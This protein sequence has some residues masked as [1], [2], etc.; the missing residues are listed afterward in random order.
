DLLLVYQGDQ[1]GAVSYE[2]L[3]V[4]CSPTRFIEDGNLPR[5]A[6]IVD[7][8]W[9]YVNKSGGPDRRFS[10]NRQLPVVQYAHLEIKSTTGLNIHLQASNIP[11]AQQFAALLRGSHARAPQEQSSRQSK[12]SRPGPSIPTPAKK[13]AYDVLGISRSATFD[14]VTAAYHKLARM[15]HPD[16]VADLAPEFKELAERRMKE[17]NAAYESLKKEFRAN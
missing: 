1:Y 13:S 11:F 7:H 5:D 12:Q 15:N 6:Q 17:I 2:S 9:K 14:D 16:R 10:N 8:T 3:S 4:E